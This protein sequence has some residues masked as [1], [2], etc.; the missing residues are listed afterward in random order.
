MCGGASVLDVKCCMCPQT[1]GPDLNIVDV[2][3]IHDNV[4]LFI[5]SSNILIMCLC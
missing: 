5:R 1:S 4:S 2:T 3:E